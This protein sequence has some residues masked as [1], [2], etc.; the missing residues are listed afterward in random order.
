MT[1]AVV[2]DGD[3][4]RVA[5]VACVGMAGI[6]GGCRI[7]AVAEVPTYAAVGRG[8]RIGEVDRVATAVRLR[9]GGLRYVAV[10][11]VRTE[12]GH[13]PI[14]AAARADLGNRIRPYIHP[15]HKAPTDIK[16]VLFVGR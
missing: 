8:S 1:A 3:A 13:E 10:A 12:L 16:I 5:S 11:V 9:K 4:Y 14:I 6:G 15:G 2:G 7:A